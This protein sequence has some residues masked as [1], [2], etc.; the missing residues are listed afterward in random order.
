MTFGNHSIAM[1]ECQDGK[2][3]NS[4]VRAE[5]YLSFLSLAPTKSI[6]IS[7]R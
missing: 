5:N 6:K 4:I 1:V 3:K 7:D 2:I